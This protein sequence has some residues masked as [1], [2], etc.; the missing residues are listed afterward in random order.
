MNNVTI[1]GR[2]TKDAEVRFSAG[3]N[4]S[5]VARMTLAVNRWNNDGADFINLVAFGKKAEFLETYGKKGTKFEV[6]GHIHTDSYEK[7]GQRIYTTDVIVDEI[8]FGES[9]RPAEQ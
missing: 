8:E 5:A 1:S 4:Q 7:N 6:R 3:E 9:K 2:A